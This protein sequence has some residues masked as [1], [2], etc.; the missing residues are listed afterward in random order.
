MNTRY[1][2]SVFMAGLL[3]LATC[4]AAV[5]ADDGCC[6]PQ[7]TSTIICTTTTP[8]PDATPASM[9]PLLTSRLQTASLLWSSLQQAMSSSPDF[10]ECAVDAIGARMS[11][12]SSVANP[13][14]AVGQIEQAIALMKSCSCSLS[15]EMATATAAMDA[16]GSTLDLSVGDVLLVSLDENPSTGYSWYFSVP[17]GVMVLCDTFESDPQADEMMSGVGG[18]R[19]LLLMVTGNSPFTISGEYMRAWEQDAI[20]EFSLFVE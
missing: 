19:K 20:E 1:Y 12:A 5:S 2:I 13:V 7:Q 6:A 11:L 15:L 18:T 8:A 3:L 16:S 14:F 17:S 4:S 10:S 9:R